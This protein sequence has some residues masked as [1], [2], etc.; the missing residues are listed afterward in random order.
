MDWKLPEN[1]LF[2]ILLRSRWWVSLLAAVG[3]FAAVRIFLDA[4][5]AFFA[6]LP[7]IVIAVVALWKQRHV[8][9][10]ARVDATIDTLRA[11]PWEEFARVLEQSYQRQGYRVRRVEGAADFELEKAGRLTLVAAKRWKASRAGVEPL[12]ELV[13]AGEA[14]GAA[15]CV[16]VLAGEMTR[17]ALEF[18]KNTNIIWVRDA[19]LVKLTAG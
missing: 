9:S 11:M 12:K 8:P 6:A 3:T 5:F 7:F 17:N 2:S 1:T 13:A 15:E 19:E 14:R 4:G 16:Y 18:G 10:R